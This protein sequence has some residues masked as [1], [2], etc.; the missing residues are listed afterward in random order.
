MQENGSGL[1]FETESAMISLQ[2]RL[3]T[4]NDKGLIGRPFSFFG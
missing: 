1:R 3:I 2:A 4:D